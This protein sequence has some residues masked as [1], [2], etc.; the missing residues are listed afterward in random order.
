LVPFVTASIVLLFSLFTV[1]SGSVALVVAALAASRFTDGTRRSYLAFLAAFTGSVFLYLVGTYV[2]TLYDQ[3]PV[4]FL[5]VWGIA[6][7]IVDLSIVVT[8]VL[9]YHQLFEVRYARR[10]APYIIATA[11]VAIVG[12][13][14][15]GSRGI[16]TSAATMPV[17]VAVG[18]V[19]YFALFAYMIALCVLRLRSLRG[20]AKRALG[21]GLFAIALVG[22]FESTISGADGWTALVSNR[23]VPSEF[24][25]SAVP[26]FL[27]TIASSVVL[28]K[29]DAQIKDQPPLDAYCDRYGVSARERDVLVAI[30]RG[31][32]NQEI[33]DRLFISVQTVK[34]HAHHLY[35]KTGTS[36]RT[37]L[38][39]SIQSFD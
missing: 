37:A 21:Y 2:L 5:V 39:A 8:A 19:Y 11:G 9:F 16:V 30:S 15:S 23:V 33:A 28:L 6:D 22:I 10:V 13:A 3:V 7:G 34:T 24:Y 12:F 29:T 14:L 26:Y 35:G 32:S 36:G 25:I 1:V 17:G 4:P 31:W 18:L 20:L 27:W 38:L